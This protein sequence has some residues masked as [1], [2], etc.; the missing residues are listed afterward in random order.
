MMSGSGGSRGKTG[1]PSKK[2]NK[3]KSSS[4]DTGGINDAAGV[5]YESGYDSD[6]DDEFDEIGHDSSDMNSLPEWAA[7]QIALGQRPTVTQVEEKHKFSYDE[8]LFGKESDRPEEQIKVHNNIRER[9]K[10]SVSKPLFDKYEV[11]IPKSKFENEEKIDLTL[12]KLENI[13]RKRGVYFVFNDGKIGRSVNLGGRYDEIEGIIIKIF[14]YDYADPKVIETITEAINEIANM[15][16]V[17]LEDDIKNLSYDKIA[18]MEEKGLPILPRLLFHLVA[19]NEAGK[20]KCILNA[21]NLNNIETAL[22]Q[23]FK[24]DYGI[25]VNEESALD[26]HLISNLMRFVR[27]S[28]DDAVDVARE[29]FGCLNTDEFDCLLKEP[30]MVEAILSWA[31]GMTTAEKEA[32]KEGITPLDAC[33]VIM[34]KIILGVSGQPDSDKYWKDTVKK[35]AGEGANIFKKDDYT[36]EDLKFGFKVLMKFIETIEKDGGIRAVD[37]NELVMKHHDKN[38]NLVEWLEGRGWQPFFSYLDLVVLRYT[39]ETEDGEPRMIFVNRPMCW[40]LFSGQYK[41]QDN[42]P[43]KMEEGDARSQARRCKTGVVL[44]H[45]FQVLRKENASLD[46][47]KPCSTVR[48]NLL[49]AFAF[50]MYLLNNLH[51]FPMVATLLAK[52]L[53]LCEHLN[54]LEKHYHRQSASEHGTNLKAQ[55][56]SRRG[57]TEYDLDKQITSKLNNVL[58]TERSDDVPLDA[59]NPTLL[60]AIDVL[61]N[62]DGSGYGK[63]QRDIDE[64]KRILGSFDSAYLLKSGCTIYDTLIQIA[65]SRNNS[66][67]TASIEGCWK[68]VDSGE[69]KENSESEDESGDGSD[70]GSD[71]GFGIGGELKKYNNNK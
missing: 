58:S 42:T 57:P 65:T 53:L 34:T 8:Y 21:I 17:K 5:A 25:D 20:I 51:V 3:I 39:K 52:Y 43:R 33:K 24:D 30:H 13:G 62:E 32:A 55:R 48:E 38:T 71:D 4:D 37:I 54:V 50:R 69:G 18:E 45:I 19:N 67:Q 70:D 64:A 66:K 9:L 7:M 16:G 46:D 29:F 44:Q 35:P 40:T 49:I 31:R 63:A 14:D 41:N 10:K 59:N 12:L 27:P 6:S 11:Y 36:D 1:S 23:S 26:E 2:K 68:N 60:K 47:I 56:K 28:M 61:L 15:P 22:T